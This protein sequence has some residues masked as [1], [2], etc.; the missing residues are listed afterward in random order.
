MHRQ[1][2][3]TRF[4]SGLVAHRH[5]VATDFARHSVFPPGWHNPERC[6][7]QHLTFLITAGAGW[8]DVWEGPDAGRHR[9][10]PG[11]L[12]WLAP[13][14]RHSTGHEADEAPPAMY[15]MRYR[16]QGRGGRTAALS[17]ACTTVP[18]AWHLRPVFD[19]WCDAWARGG[20]VAGAQ[21]QSCCQ[22]V[23][24][25]VVDLLL[26]AAQSGPGLSLERQAQI[27]A[28]LREHEAA[29]VDAA[30]LATICGL[31]RVH[32]TRLFTATYGMPPRVWLVEQRLQRAAALLQ[33]GGGA[34]GA[35]AAACGWRSTPLFCRQ[36]RRL[37]GCTPGQWQHRH[38]SPHVG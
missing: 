35:V 8:V 11:L 17:V 19:H 4:V 14:C 12:V 5:A 37:Y 33:Q 6:L 15:H 18:E 20:P 7:E 28:F 13:G 26:R 38:W 32:F 3:F 29:A 9:L 21:Q 16:L 25:G 36:F 27:A 22:L 23:A 1:Q 2:A 31:G 24:A 34:V 30:D 10:R